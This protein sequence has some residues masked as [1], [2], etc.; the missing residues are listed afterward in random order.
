MSRPVQQEVEGIC[1][2]AKCHSLDVERKHNQDK[3]SEG[4][5][6]I[7]VSAASRNSILQRYRLQRSKVIAES[8]KD[9]RRAASPRGQT[10]SS[11]ELANCG[12]N[13]RGLRLRGRLSLTL[14][15]RQHYKLISMNIH[16]G[17]QRKCKRST[18]EH[19]VFSTAR[20][21]ERRSLTRNGWNG[22]GSTTPNSEPC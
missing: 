18:Q 6:V 19:A 12:G 4:R 22:L 10:C 9:R 1:W 13:L 14:A 7:S 8:I 21:E 2:N 17:S 20:P 16:R 15:T 11:V 3:A 5:R